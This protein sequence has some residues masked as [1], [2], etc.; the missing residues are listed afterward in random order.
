MEEVPLTSSPSLTTPQ[1]VDSD[2]E[3][4]SSPDKLLGFDYLFEEDPETFGLFPDEI[5]DY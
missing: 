5:P 1:P 4:Y 3:V 2:P